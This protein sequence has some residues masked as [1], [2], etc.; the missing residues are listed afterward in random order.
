MANGSI[1]LLHTGVICPVKRP[2][3]G[4]PP[5]PSKRLPRVNCI[6]TVQHYCVACCSPRRGMQG[7]EPQWEL[8]LPQFI[9]FPLCYIHGGVNHMKNKLDWFDDN[10]NW[11]VRPTRVLYELLLSPTYRWPMRVKEVYSFKWGVEF[12]QCPRCG[13][14]MEREYQLFCDRCG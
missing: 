7:F 12:P 2:P 13:T 8:T 10:W 5:E 9:R 4:K 1:S 11:D 3:N 6:A 14:T